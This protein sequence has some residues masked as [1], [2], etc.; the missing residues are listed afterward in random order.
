MPEGRRLLGLPPSLTAPASVH[1]RAA[2]LRAAGVTHV[3]IAGATFTLDP[4]IGLD[5][6]ARLERNPVNGMPLPSA[7]LLYAV[8]YLCGLRAIP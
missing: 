4:C 8:R 6:V 2:P 5:E 7:R 1:L 3:Y